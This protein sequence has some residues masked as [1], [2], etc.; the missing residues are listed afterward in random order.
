MRCEAVSLEQARE[1]ERSINPGARA[2]MWF[3]EEATIEPRLLM[4]ALLTAAQR[5]GVEIRANCAVTN[6]ICEGDRCSGVIA[7]SERISAKHVIVAAGCFSQTIAENESG[8]SDV[9]ARYAPTHPVRGQMIALQSRGVKLRRVL[10]SK[11]RYVVPR[12]DGRIV[13]GSTLEDLG[14][15]KNVST[16]RRA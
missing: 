3:P 6:L 8:G 2:A 13:A 15:Q 16:D 7:G 11:G 12:H 1:L 14:F 9:L 10:R 4:D 5:R